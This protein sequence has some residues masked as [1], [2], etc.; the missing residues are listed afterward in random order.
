M[1]AMHRWD[2]PGALG[3]RASCYGRLIGFRRKA[4]SAATAR[5]ATLTGTATAT[6]SGRCFQILR[7]GKHLRIEHCLFAPTL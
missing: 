4:A 3:P 1:R 5:A 7:T 6:R 2:G